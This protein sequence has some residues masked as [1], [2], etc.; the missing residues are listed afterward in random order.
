M[1]AFFCNVLF[2]K[3]GGGK[4]GADARCAQSASR[5]KLAAPTDI[6]GAPF[7]ERLIYAITLDA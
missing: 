6:N 7:R 5:G 1:K 3:A 4:G 2:D